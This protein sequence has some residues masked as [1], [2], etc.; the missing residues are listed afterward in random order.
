MK[1]IKLLSAA[2]YKD[3][4]ITIEF[5]DSWDITVLGDQILPEIPP[6]SIKEQ[7][8]NPVGS[9]TLNQLAKNRTRA[10]IIVDDLTRPTPADILVDVVLV[11][12]ANAGIPNE[13]IT[14]I[15]G[16]GA[17]KPATGDDIRR[18]LGP[19]I[20][21]SI[22]VK[23]H[24]SHEDLIFLGTTSKGTPLYINREVYEN[25]LKIGVGCIYPHPAAGFSGGSKIHVTGCCWL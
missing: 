6:A 8:K 16:G 19:N 1:E 15:V 4:Q 24:D 11:E 5:P 13:A 17:H 22:R 10:V 9:K 7:I 23:P 12:L 2:W 25:D 18:K 21:S 14:I 20:P 3:E